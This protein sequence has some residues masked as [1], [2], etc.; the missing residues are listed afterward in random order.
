L[1]IEGPDL[2]AFDD[3]WCGCVEVLGGSAGPYSLSKSGLSDGFGPDVLL[4]IG[5]EA[6]LM[7]FWSVC[8]SYQPSASSPLFLAC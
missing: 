7:A 5:S 8:G 6:F 2:G 1:G 3:G 4:E